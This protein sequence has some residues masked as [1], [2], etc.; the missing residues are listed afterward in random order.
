MAVLTTTQTTLDGR[1]VTLRYLDPTHAYALDRVLGVLVIAFDDFDRILALQDGN[2]LS[3]PGGKVEW[4][5]EAPEAAAINRVLECASVTLA[6][7][8]LAAVIEAHVKDAPDQFTNTLVMTSRVRVIEPFKPLQKTR[9]RLFITPE[10]LLQ[11]CPAAQRED[12]RS[13]IA[14]A[15]FAVVDHPSPR[16]VTKTSTA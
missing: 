7:P 11:S 8:R 6:L 1:E 10:S 4:D 12:L 14:K 9:K 15:A 2:S 3:L 5:E 16:F 13:L